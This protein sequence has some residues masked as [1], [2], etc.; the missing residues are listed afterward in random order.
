MHDHAAH[1]AV[2]APGEFEA[3]GRSV[4]KTDTNDAKAIAFSSARVFR[5]WG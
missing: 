4:K 3:I 5:K 2:V 1:V